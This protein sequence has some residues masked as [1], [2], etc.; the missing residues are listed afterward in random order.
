MTFTCK[1][2]QIIGEPLST[3]F[4]T[5]AASPM[6]LNVIL[7]NAGVNTINYDFQSWNGTAWVDM[8]APGSDFNNTL[9]A[10]EVLAVQIPASNSKVRLIGNAS[11]GSFLY[12]EYTTYMAR[13]S[14]GEVMVYASAPGGPICP[15]GSW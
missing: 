5:V 15:G 10:N 7:Q 9:V 3:L 2:S 8:G 1:D 14:G 12:F 11:G 4:S 6:G 13:A